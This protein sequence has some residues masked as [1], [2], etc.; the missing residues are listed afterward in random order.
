[1]PG[2]LSVVGYDDMSFSSTRRIDLTT[3]HQ[4]RI[5]LGEQAVRVVLDRL[6]D[7][8]RRV[9]DVILPHT[10]VV[11]STTAPPGGTSSGQRRG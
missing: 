2:D 9:E 3:V 10:F 5:E 1:V 11:R 6:A 4:P 8:E 7:P